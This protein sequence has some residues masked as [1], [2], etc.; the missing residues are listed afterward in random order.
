PPLLEALNAGAIDIGSTGETPPIFA[1]A[2]GTPLLYVAVQSGSG[3][4]S[5]LLVAAGSPLQSPQELKGKKIAFTKASSAHLLLIKALKQQGLQYSDI[6]PVLL[7]PPE[8]RA[9]FE[10]GSVDAWVV[11]NP[12]RES[13]IQELNARELV[14]GGTVAPTKGYIEASDSF[15]RS[16]PELVTAVVEELQAVQIWA[17]GHLEEYA[18]ILEKETEIPA[19]VWIAGFDSDATEYALIDPATVEYQQEVA[20]L[21]YELK[22]IPEPLEISK[23][24]W[25]VDQVEKED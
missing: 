18:A 5:G 1:Q 6:E 17:K 9:A 14:N 15:A 13:A 4:G 3:A 25:S 8:A 19:A 7:A 20:D 11:W 16:N 10:G 21:F 23:V 24:V 12:F 22:L 2:A